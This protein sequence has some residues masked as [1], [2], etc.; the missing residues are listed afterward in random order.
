MTKRFHA[1]AFDSGTLLKLEIFRGYIRKWLPVFLSKVSYPNVNIFDFFAGPG[2]DRRGKEGSPL[3]ILNEL[4]KYLHDPSIPKASEVCINVYFNDDNEQNIK[5]LKKNI[6]EVTRDPSAYNIKFANKDF[7]IAFM[8]KLPGLKRHDTANLV[9]LDQFGLKQINDRIFHELISCPTTDIL[10]FISSSYIKRFISEGCI[11]QYFPL[12]ED[13]LKQ[14]SSKEIHRYICNNFYRDL[15]PKGYEYYLAPF[16]IQKDNT[17]NIYGLI[18]GSS[19]LFGLQKFLEV[20]WDKDSVTGEANYNI[21]NDY[22]PDN[23]QLSLLPE[24]NIIKKQD[25][26]K[27][28]L[29]DY[30][31]SKRPTNK[32]LYRFS[33][34]NGFLSGH[35]KDILREQ[36]KSNKLEVR[37]PKTNENA[38]TGAFYITWGNYKKHEARARFSIKKVQR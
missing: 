25:Q 14:V 2:K 29:V 9:I 7:E 23:G 18:F 16:S 22:I 17:P 6:S 12:P 32:G 8:E 30:I 21:D 37:D 10:F 38:R 15:I 33:L 31:K 11:K 35:A 4:N 5:D 20:C 13:E 34:E 26:F 24:D 28:D 3:I 36:Q 19:S 1:E 27:K